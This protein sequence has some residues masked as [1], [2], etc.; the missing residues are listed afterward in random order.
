M[1]RGAAV[2]PCHV[3][4][5]ASVSPDIIHAGEVV[6]IT[7]FARTSCPPITPTIHIV[8]VLDGSEA[9]SGEPS[10]EQKQAMRT[11]VQGLELEDHPAI[12]VGVVG[13][14]NGQAQTLCPLTHDLAQINGCID[15]LGAAG[16]PNLEAAIEAARTLIVQAPSGDRPADEVNEVVLLSSG[17]PLEI[18]CDRLVQSAG[19]LRG[20]GVFLPVV[21][22][23]PMCDERCLRQ[24]G[25][26]P[27]FYFDHMNAG[28]IGDVLEMQERWVFGPTLVSQMIITETI[29]P[30]AEFVANSA[31]PTPDAVSPDGR[32]L[33]WRTSLVPSEGITLNLQARPSRLGMNALASAT[34]SIT[35]N[36]A[37]GRAFTFPLQ[38]VMVLAPDPVET[39]TPVGGG[40]D[41]TATPKGTGTPTLESTPTP[42]SREWTIY[43]PRTSRSP[44]PSTAMSRATGH[45]PYQ[46]FRPQ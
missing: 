20:R 35:D 45:A 40:P 42:G 7:L 43:L 11:I 32:T 12:K 44:G 31:Q 29:S 34:G 14:A 27:R 9:M 10:I 5:R 38:A 23:G 26:S 13:H 2:S 25:T 4:T 1:Q 36:A 19:T 18:T 39:A 24:V 15:Q 22:A 21:C 8:L 41:V 28:A 17:A 6:S 33:T 16:S 37:L 30:G 46:G 3:D